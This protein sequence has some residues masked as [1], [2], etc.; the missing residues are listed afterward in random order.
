[1]KI[2]VLGGSVFLSRQV[3]VEA[4]AR[5]HQVVCA[6][7]ASSGAVPEGVEHVVLDRAS[8]TDPGSLPWTA[9]AGG[10]FDAVV[11][12]ARTPSWVRTAV[13]ALSS[14]RPHWVFVSSVSAYA[15]LSRPG[16]T[17]ADTT[18][19]EAAD[20]DLDDTGGDA[21]AYGRNKVACEQE[22]R[23]GSGGQCLV[24]RPGLIV[25]PHDP[26]GRFTYW[27]VRMARGGRVLAPGPPDDPVQ[28]V[29]VRDLAAWLVD[30]C[31]QRLVGTFDGVGPAWPRSKFLTAVAQG[32]GTDPELVWAGPGALADLDVRPWSGER[33]LPVWVP[34]PEMAGMLA[35][36]VSASL[37]AGLACRPVAQSARDTLDWVRAAEQATVTGLTAVEEAQVLIGIQRLS[38]EDLT[39]AQSSSSPPSSSSSSSSSSSPSS[40]SPPSS[41]GAAG[42]G[43]T[44]WAGGGGGGAGGELASSAARAA[45]AAKASR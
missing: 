25:G 30:G 42:T 2:L 20:G 14:V 17:V 38:A 22:V 24:V 26:T 21:T 3:A 10:R 4:I 19:H 9:L 1:M 23:T 39:R 5:G 28:V 8:N 29:D 45:S 27:P 32:V 13:S 6:C 11:D 31:E 35:R 40:S 7:R 37:Q 36:D 34:L 44:G 12:V 33:S 16:G 15:D 43:S 41:P 18:L